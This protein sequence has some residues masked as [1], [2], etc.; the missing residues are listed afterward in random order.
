MFKKKKDYDKAQRDWEALRA[1]NEGD[2]S[3]SVGQKKVDTKFAEDYNDWTSGSADRTLS[4]IQKID[5]VIT[6]LKEGKG[7]TGGLTGMFGD[8]FT[9]SDVLAN[10]A[11][12]QQSAMTLIKTLLSGATSD[13]DREQ[14]VNT[15]WNEADS[16]ENNIARLK[17]FSNNMK[18]KYE[19]TN[20]KAKYF[21]STKGTLK[22]FSPITNKK[23]NINQ[24]QNKTEFK[25]NEL[26]WAD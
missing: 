6:R 24:T 11:A 10:R 14:I 5:N 18:S 17:E 22:G 13:K 8:R 23:T 20:Q 26:D 16:T 19:E 2:N 12:A 1:K 4:E 25:T 21:E 15:L 7:T 3:A 9:S